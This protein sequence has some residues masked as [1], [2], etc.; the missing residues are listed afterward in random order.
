MRYWIY[1]KHPDAAHWVYDE[2]M[3]ELNNDGWNSPEDTRRLLQQSNHTDYVVVGLEYFI[4]PPYTLRVQ[5]HKK[6]G[7]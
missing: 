1:F 2:P 3:N 4:E 6:A 5:Q 7:A